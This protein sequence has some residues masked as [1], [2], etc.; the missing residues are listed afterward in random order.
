MGTKKKTSGKR[1]K[2]DV[3]SAMG[4]LYES[5]EEEDASDDDKQE[6]RDTSVDEKSTPVE[7]TMTK[8]KKKS[9]RKRKKAIVAKSDDVEDQG[10][11]NSE[12]SALSYLLAPLTIIWNLL[13][14]LLGFVL[15][16]ALGKPKRK[17]K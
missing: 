6:P 15:K 2:G 7:S 14:S 11:L 3:F 8:S 4:D 13:V 16:M 1:S 17:Q 12:D 10:D 9:K 5:S